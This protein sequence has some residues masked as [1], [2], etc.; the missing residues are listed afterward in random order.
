MENDD[1]KATNRATLAILAK[2][3]ANWPR[4]ALSVGY[5][6]ICVPRRCCHLQG[7]IGRSLFI[8]AAVLVFVSDVCS[9]L[10]SD[11]GRTVG[12]TQ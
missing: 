12:R 8:L 5:G 1:P 4:N 7:W 11:N 2:E 10:R 9:L 6:R 3:A